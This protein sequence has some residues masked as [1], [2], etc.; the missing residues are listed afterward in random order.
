MTGPNGSQSRPPVVPAT[1]RVRDE[2]ADLPHTS[3]PVLPGLAHLTR[4][5]AGAAHLPG[6]PGVLV[7]LDPTLK[8]DAVAGVDACTHTP[9]IILGTDLLHQENPDQL[10]MV[11]A[12]EIAHHVLD[13]DAEPGARVWSTLT[14]ALF[15][16]SLGALFLA[17]PRWIVVAATDAALAVHLIGR[18][19]ATRASRRQ[20]LAADA[21]AVRLLD[22]IG[23]NG[24]AT[25]TACLATL[26]AA[27]RWH[28]L[29]GWMLDSHPSPAMRLRHLATD[30]R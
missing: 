3:S 2:G 25:L 22:A 30:H 5:L 27:S 16:L 6:T 17:A 9:R 14:S 26:P 11:V 1:I 12:H 7:T 4:A 24:R 20:E 13:H 8:A 29:I 21:H 28:R 15:L 23:R 19:A 10:T 18:L